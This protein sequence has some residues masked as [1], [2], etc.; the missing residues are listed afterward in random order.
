MTPLDLTRSSVELTADLVD[1]FS[2]S[3]SE[4]EVADL[5]EQALRPLAHLEV[6]R[7][8]DAVIARTDLARERR[9]VIAGHLD[10]VPLHDNFPSTVDGEAI[11]GCGTSDMKSGSA[12]ALHLA[13][14]VAE[15]SVD[16]KIQPDSS[17]Q[18]AKGVVKPSIVKTVCR[19]FMT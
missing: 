1:V 13:M 9:A 12:L 15:P 19:S 4:A 11:Y 16:V 10:T 3:G 14:T 8:G 6:L 17:L 2:V 5:V 18:I 7:D